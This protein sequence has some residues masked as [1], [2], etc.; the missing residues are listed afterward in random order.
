MHPGKEQT[1]NLAAAWY[2]KGQNNLKYAVEI[3]LKGL[4]LH[5]DSELLYKQAISLHL[6][7][8][9]VIIKECNEQPSDDL[10]NKKK[11]YIEKVNIFLDM[12]FKNIKRYNF[13]FE[14]LDLLETYDFTLDLKKSIL[15]KI[16]E[17]YSQEPL[18]WHNLAQR[19]HRGLDNDNAP[20]A[21]IAERRLQLCISKY[22]EGLNKIPQS[23]KPQLWSTFL[24][25]LIQCRER[26]KLKVEDLNEYLKRAH[27]SR[28]L[29]E[30]YYDYWL[31]LNK[32]DYSELILKKATEAYPT[33]EKWF[34]LYLRYKILKHHPKEEINVIFSKGKEILGE[35]AVNLWTI[36]IQYHIVTSPDDVIQTY[37]LKGIKEGDKISLALRSQYIEWLRL[38][39]GITEARNA[40]ADL[41][42]MLPYCKN[43]HTTML[44][45]ESVECDIDRMENIHK[46]LTEQFPR[47]LDVWINIM[48]FYEYFRRKDPVKKRSADTNKVYSKALCMLPEPLQKQFKEKCGHIVLSS[49]NFN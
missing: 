10:K 49:T 2:A 22:L 25:Y 6:S 12:V 14:L 4:V 8:A 19:C 46:T 13:Y 37:F 24:D 27:D 21:D 18:V 20:A 23:K 34:E 39:R 42:C 29:P 30:K 26:N 43:L 38:S 9:N 11:M 47:D 32:N 28:C 15:N 1:W 48:E 3:L 41:A 35:K 33:S 17:E 5:P 7:K 40:Y 16:V 36:F 31:T 44:N 45:I